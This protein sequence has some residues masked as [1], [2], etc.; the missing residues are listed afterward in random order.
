MKMEAVKRVIQFDYYFAVDNIG[1]S[2]GLALLWKQEI[3]LNIE[4]FIKWHI[5]G[6]MTDQLNG[7]QWW[8]TGFY[9]HP[10]ATKRTLSWSLLK[11]LKPNSNIL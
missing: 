6:I 5:G 7:N 8:I 3:N 11:E 9:G 10:D 1:R 4:S 2:C